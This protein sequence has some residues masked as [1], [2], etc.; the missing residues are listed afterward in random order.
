M[1]PG[2]DD[3][4]IIVIPAG[5]SAPP[6]V[7]ALT[8]TRWGGV[9]RTPFDSL[10]LGGHVEDD[11]AAVR[12]NRQRLRGQCGLSRE[13]VWLHQ[14]HGTTIVRADTYGAGEDADGSYTENIGVACAI[15][16]ADCLP[17]F[18]CSA[19]GTLVGLFHVGWRGLVQGMVRKAAGR[20]LRRGGALAWLG[21]AIGPGAFEIGAEVKAEI[22]HGLGAGE[23]AFRSARNGKWYANLYLLV[24]DEL[25]RL[26]VG[27]RY[28]EEICTYADADRFFSYRRSKCCGRMAS[29]IWMDR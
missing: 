15:L 3:R 23:G 13:P 5:W 20:F 10:N 14:V 9:S 22:Q 26:G 29:L 25:E 19:D 1:R 27:C 17:L 12:E 8:T 18:M 11:I 24:A 21:P 4:P 6:R 16:T 28:D 7:R 2:R